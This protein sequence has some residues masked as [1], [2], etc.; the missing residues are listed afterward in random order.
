MQDVNPGSAVDVVMRAQPGS[1]RL[2]HAQ[3]HGEVELL[4][5]RLLKLLG[6]ARGEGPAGEAAEPSSA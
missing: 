6:D 4:R 1:Y 3:L 5:A 2:E